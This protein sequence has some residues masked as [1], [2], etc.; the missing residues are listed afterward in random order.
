MNLAHL[1]TF[2][3]LRY[4]LRVNQMRRAGL[5]S[6]VIQAVLAV[7]V[8]VA[9]LGLFVGMLLFGLFALGAAAPAVV[10]YVCDGLIVLFL[11]VWAGGLLT[12]LQ[13]TDVLSME[14]FLHLPVSPA[15]VFLINYLSSLLSVTL[16]L[17][18]PG[19]L[20]LTLGLTFSRGPVLLLLLP[21][22]AAFVLLVT[23]VTHLLRSALAAL[24]V[25]P[26][27][28]RTILVFA[29]MT[30]VLVFQLPQLVNVFVP[31]KSGAGLTQINARKTQQ[32]EELLRLLNQHKITPEQYQARQRQ[33]QQA[34]DNEL[35][36]SAERVGSRAEQ[37]ASVVNLAFPPGWLAVGARLAAGG[38][39]Q[40][41][42][43]VLP[44]AGMALL[45]AACLW[46]SYRTT[47]RL[48]RGELTSGGADAPSAAPRRRPAG[49][50]ATGLL[51]WELP[52]VSEQAAAVALAGFRSLLR[53]PEA[54]MLLLTPVIMVVVFGALFLQN[55][56][57]AHASLRPLMAA[58][59]I[60]MVLFGF[61]NFVG[62]QFGY[63]RSGFRVFVLCSAPRRDI[64]LG[65]NLSTAPLVLLLSAV[66]VIFLE[67]FQ[68]LRPD[69]LLAL[70][71]LAASM[72]LLFCLA[73]NLLSIL[74][75]VAVNPGTMR[76]T[77]INGV[78]LLWHFGFAMLL[79][80]LMGLTLLP[81]GL[82]VLLDWLADIRGWPIFLV[83]AT[84]EFGL[85][86]LL[87]RLLLGFEGRLL[88]A[89]EKKILE[90]VTTKEE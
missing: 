13:Q 46:R 18:V 7:L 67:V 26:R 83:L 40:P 25:N 10:L 89:R 41:V 11:M 51:E 22:T 61:S 84:A 73:A 1:R 4:R 86:L 19:M 42:L 27:R 17:F 57:E 15:G 69:H 81:L 12:D 23:G 20:G 24:M 59:G 85:V 3:W 66:L 6:T 16:L 47:L 71:P 2:L 68:P 77:G 14:R 60:L 78:T 34:Y 62:N 33:V 31:W 21:L 37:I 43:T 35:K 30:L 63:D 28:R 70:L 8:L 9:A 38:G 50:P 52:L 58:G 76:A 65:K 55:P 82:E 74:A 32:N 88:E 79:P 48:Y 87:Y 90:A 49:P 36:A 64:L 53:A 75:P 80:T 5:A 54:K 44:G 39:W 45:G 29:T 72:F 56:F